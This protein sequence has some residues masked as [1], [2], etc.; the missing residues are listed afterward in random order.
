MLK[1]LGAGLLLGLCG[2]G[3]LL[4][5]ARL[6]SGLFADFE[7]ATF[8]M[9]YRDALSA[10]RGTIEEIVI[11]DI[12]SRSLY[13]LGRFQDWP[14][15]YHTAVLDTLTSQGALAVF[16]DLLLVERARDPEQDRRLV[17]AVRRAG[18]VYAALLFS[19][20]DTLN[21]IYP[22]TKD[23]VAASR[24]RAGL[25]VRGGAALPLADLVETPFPELL[26][27]CAGVGAVNWG[28]AGDN[29][30]RR[31]PLLYRLLDRVYPTV[32][33]RMA[34]DLLGASPDG[35]AFDP[36]DGIT[37]Y[38]SERRTVPADARGL[39][40]LDY[41]GPW[42]TFRYVS[43]YDV[44][45]GRIAPGFFA[46]KIAM[47]G[48]SAPGLSDLATTPFQHAYPRVELHAT[49][50]YNLL[51]GRFLQRASDGILLASV[52]VFALI[53]GALAI[54]LRPI[55]ALACLATLVIAYWL[56][57]GA[58]FE[59]QRLWLGVVKPVSS[60][61]MAFGLVLFYRYWTEER[62]KHRIRAAFQHYVPL[63]V[64]EEIVND[65]SYLGL[66]GQRQ[67]LTVLF[68][69]IKGFT[70]IAERLDS[71]ELAR[72]MNE[73]LGS[74]THLVFARRGTLDKYVGDMIM[75]IYG[76]PV[77]FPEHPA[78]ACE[79]ALDMLA[80]LDEFN[81]RH[82]P[83]SR[84]DIGIGINSGSM[85]VG[86][87]GS[88]IRFAYTVTGDVVNLASRLEGLTRHYDNRVIVGEE[89][90]RAAGD[91]FV[92]RRLDRVHVKGKTQP[93]TVY[94]LV[95]RGAELDALSAERL[96]GFEVAQEAYFAGEWGRA[97][98]LLEQLHLQWADD[99]PTRVF[100]ERCRHF[101]QRP[102]E[103]GWDGTWTMQEK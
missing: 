70:T 74:M 95:G 98:E 10:P 4:L 31:F 99:G 27:A 29:V 80:G 41:P 101:S 56:V 35:L 13:K 47:I 82:S 34:A 8:D 68:S 62:E 89:T 11:V 46:G 7:A 71:E 90:Y 12:D 83:G 6:L 30:V 73:Y 60:G 48:S 77:A 79:T 14:R 87:M 102:P 16:L 3:L 78:A 45:A 17:E 55:Y 85:W 36:E 86:N 53:A 5:C 76:A 58:Y 1:R 59:Q 67:N 23:P 28:I 92:M 93:E 66:G 51:A 26:V 38:G 18:N 64:V 94:E 50:L 2:S 65:P 44:L 88:E 9:R 61:L 42:K 15:A 32:A 69:D 52:L 54:L 57:A 33:L 81:R 40:W 24:P 22:Q 39:L 20:A 25:A 21:F 63:E 103:V 72:L 49:L 96:A 37:I 84:L 97:L 43:Y 91:A 100:L 75:A 19:H